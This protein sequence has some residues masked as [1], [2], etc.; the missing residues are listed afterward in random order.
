MKVP[1]SWLSEYVDIDMSLDELAHR[2]TM[3][4]N[5]VDS[6]ERTGWIDNVV[7][8]HVKAV[9][10]HPDADRL[11]LVT[12]DYGGGEAEVVC[13]APNVAN[14][15][16]IAYAS[17]GAVLFDAYADEPGNTRKLKRSKIRGVASDGM[18]CSVR[19]LGIGDDHD[20]ILVLDEGAR[21]GT[22]IGEVIGESV[23][24]I[25]L[26]PNRPDCLGVVG[27]ARDVAAIT[28]N[29]LREPDIS[30]KA[31]G[32]DVGGLA[33][34][35]IADPDLCPR[36]TAAVIQG[37]KIGPSP[38][39]LQDRLM[40]IGERPINSIVDI[41]N[42]VMFE[43]GQPLHAFDYDKVVDYRVIV[44]RAAAGE[45]LVTLDDKKWRI[46]RGRG[47]GCWRRR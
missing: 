18:V 35:E 24:D 45:K 39:W 36:Y 19:E 34:V 40:A 29:K 41:T 33:T 9:R 2:L 27:V 3:A 47:A 28:G 14:G 13:G 11:R 22:P 43:L 4:G 16:K 30:Y 26:T 32:P 15:Q 12:V 31:T 10:P 21:I 7:V 46:R 5:E 8:G 25:E 37:V 38:K 1:V 20:G 23:L 44:R 17:I 42:F 6:I